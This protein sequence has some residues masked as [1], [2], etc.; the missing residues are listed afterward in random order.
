MLTLPLTYALNSDALVG[1]LI[2]LVIAIRSPEIHIAI[3]WS[4]HF[5]VWVTFHIDTL[6]QF[7]VTSEV[8]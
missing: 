5:V 8:I 7:P 6:H 3:E 1:A 2:V 4:V